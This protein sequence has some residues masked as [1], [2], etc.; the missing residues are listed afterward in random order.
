MATANTARGVAPISRSGL[1]HLFVVYAGW[2]GTYLAIRVAVR[3]G[4]GFPPFT[5]GG[6]RVLLAGAI[7]L[8]LGLLARSRIKISASE[9]AVLAASGVLMWVGGNGLVVWAEQHAHSGLAA[10]L[11]SA[12]PI[13]VAMM[14]SFL[15]RRPPSRLLVLALLVGFLGVAVLSGPVLAQGTGADLA[16]IVALVVAPIAFGAGSLLQ[17]RRPAELGLFVRSGYQHLSG[18]AAF[19]TLAAILREPAPTPT[20][21]AWWA[22][23]Y[24]VVFGSIFA[25]TSYVQALK[26]L[27]TSI[28][29]TYAYVNP[30]GA[31]ILGAIILGEPITAWTVVGAALVLLGVATT[32]RERQQAAGATPG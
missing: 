16:A 8:S 25:F 28:A 10:L 5:M 32:F 27:P 29:M 22:W 30:V 13:W 31:V 3:E 2:S 7:L 15:D 12:T 20:A 6:T 18:G 9:A 26:L 17:Q 4:G 19:V 1:L 14:E 21:E 23:G 24:L 11:V